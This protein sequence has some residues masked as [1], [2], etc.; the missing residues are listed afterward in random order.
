VWERSTGRVGG[1]IEFSRPAFVR[2]LNTGT[3]GIPRS[4]RRVAR[5]GGK[6]FPLT[7]PA[8]TWAS[9][10][11]LCE[12]SRSGSTRLASRRFFQEEDLVSEPP[13]AE[14]GWRMR[15]K[16]A[17]YHY[18]GGRRL[19][20]FF[21]AAS[22]GRRTHMTMGLT[23]QGDAVQ[24]AGGLSDRFPAEVYHAEFPQ[25]LSWGI[26]T[27]TK[28]SPTNR[29][30]VF[31]ADVGLDM[32]PK[33]VFLHRRFHRSRARAR[34]RAVS[35]VCAVRVP[36]PPCADFAMSTASWLIADEIQTGRCTHRQDVLDRPIRGVVPDLINTWAQGVWA[37]GFF[38]L[39]PLFG[40]ERA[41]RDDH[42][43]A[44]ATRG[45]P[46]RKRTAA[47]PHQASL[48]APCPCMDVIE[49]EDLCG[50]GKGPVGVGN[51]CGIIS[52]G[53]CQAASLHRRCARARVRWWPSSW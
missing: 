5:T 24:A 39:V 22:T 33:S 48:A 20:A 25:A 6:P 38:L 37:V 23:G 8:F 40:G 11:V 32:D 10:R 29:P 35:N 42:G 13:A 7:Q 9:L 17:R 12:A 52:K 15:S 53:P 46:G 1:Y 19:V 18:Q 51:A 27:E 30:V 21:G 16:I 3:T 26:T 49:S 43:N 34:P 28:H 47:N 50:K 2:L 41:R 14:G 45:G 36:A 31:H 44:G 4:W